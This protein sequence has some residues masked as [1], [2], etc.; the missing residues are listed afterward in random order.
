MYG[1][2]LTAHPMIIKFLPLLM[3]YLA[4]QSI[5]FGASAPN[6]QSAGSFVKISASTALIGGS[7]LTGP[8]APTVVYIR[9]E[10]IVSMAINAD[11]GRD[12]FVVI[13]VGVAAE[14]GDRGAAALTY[15]YQ[16]SDE[17]TAVSFCEA[18]VSAI[19]G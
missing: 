19:R 7:R 13:T 17:S 6:A 4:A 5:A 11:R 16:L 3:V 15:T 1:W 2:R 18:L 12:W 9:K 8:D 14:P 10:S